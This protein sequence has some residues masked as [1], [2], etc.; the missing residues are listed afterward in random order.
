MGEVV[1]ALQGF[2]GPRKNIADQLRGLTELKS[3]IVVG[4][5]EYRRTTNRE[6]HFRR[7]FAEVFRNSSF[8]FLGAGLAEPYFLNLFDEIIE[9]PAPR[10]I[11]ISPSFRKVRWI[12]TSCDG[13]SISTVRFTSPATINLFARS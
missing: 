2:L 8:L 5:A 10:T 7:C 1:W 13:A 6:P 4:H 3:E 9:L 12:L 11:L